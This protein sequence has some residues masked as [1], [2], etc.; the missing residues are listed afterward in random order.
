MQW[1]QRLLKLLDA[2]SV[3]STQ[4]NESPIQFIK[5]MQRVNVTGAANYAVKICSSLP[6]PEVRK[7]VFRRINMFRS[8]EFF[9]KAFFSPL[10]RKILS[11][12]SF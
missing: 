11:V 12:N 9:G 5:A 3:L 4:F 2:D 6:I 7:A 8:I 1:A 10:I